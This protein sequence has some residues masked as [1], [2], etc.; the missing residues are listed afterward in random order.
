[1]DSSGTVH[2]AV[3]LR[4]INGPRVSS[5]YEI[6]CVQCPKYR[7]SNPTS[8][9]RHSV[10]LP[11]HCLGTPR[12]NTHNSPIDSSTAVAVGAILNNLDLRAKRAECY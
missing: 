9:M 1:M 10:D 5:V 2:V 7:E 3:D 6:G 8:G 4:T 12:P 11:L